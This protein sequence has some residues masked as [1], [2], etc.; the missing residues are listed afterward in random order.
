MTRYWIIFWSSATVIASLYYLVFR[1]R[2]IKEAQY[3][4]RFFFFGAFVFALVILIIFTIE[5]ILSK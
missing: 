2:L 1:R 4:V 3:E 5:L